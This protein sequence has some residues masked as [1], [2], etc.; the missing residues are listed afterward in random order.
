MVKGLIT[1]PDIHVSPVAIVKLIMK[2]TK[3]Q[4]VNNHPDDNT[5]RS[6]SPQDGG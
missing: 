3:L 1:V 5:A 6:L 4:K 2:L